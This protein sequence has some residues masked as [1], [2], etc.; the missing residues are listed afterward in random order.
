MTSGLEL[1]TDSATDAL[2]RQM[3]TVFPVSMVRFEIQLMEPVSALPDTQSLLLVLHAISVEHV[4]Q[5][6]LVQLEERIVV[7]RIQ[8]SASHV[9]QMLLE[10]HLENVSALVVGHLPTVQSMK[11]TA[12]LYAGSTKL[13]AA[14]LDQLQITV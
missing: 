7:V 13:Q 12:H 14:V 11:E 10:T 1:A 5:G 2:D 4:I 9:G 8:I 6:A 3:K